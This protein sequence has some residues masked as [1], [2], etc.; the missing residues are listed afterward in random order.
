MDHAHASPEE[1][2]EAAEKVREAAESKRLSV[3]RIDNEHAAYMAKR[4]QAS[5]YT[6]LARMYINMGD[7]CY[8]I[9]KLAVFENFILFVI[10]VASIT[11]S[12]ETYEALEGNAVIGMIDQII[13][14]CFTMEVVLKIFGETFR[15]W[16]YFVG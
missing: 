2:S 7:Y 9:T 12:V 16:M 6:G 15:P 3:E 10:V 1:E 11:I 5:Q 8:H 4:S 14:G 13:L